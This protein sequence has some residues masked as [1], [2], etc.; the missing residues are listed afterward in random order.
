[1]TG[2]WDFNQAA[3]QEQQEADQT[4]HVLR[5]QIQQRIGA[6][7]AQLRSHGVKGDFALASARHAASDLDLGE[8]VGGMV[9]S[10]CLWGPVAMAFGH[11]AASNFCYGNDHSS[12]SMAGLT[13]GLGLLVDAEIDGVAGAKKRKVCSYYPEGRRQSRLDAANDMFG[14]FNAASKGRSLAHYSHRE[15]QLE[16]QFMQTLL[17]ALGRLD[18]DNKGYEFTEETKMQGAGRKAQSLA[19]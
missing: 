16:K 12:F 14:H 6:L 13:E 18:R 4:V 10:L 19:A 2:F 15:L 7:Q 3:K 8:A 17:K 5:R 9:V 1:M 11:D